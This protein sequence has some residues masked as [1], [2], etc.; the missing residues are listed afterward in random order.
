MNKTTNNIISLI[1]SKNFYEAKRLIHESMNQKLGSLLEEKLIEYA[2]TIYEDAPP[3]PFNSKGVPVEPFKPTPPTKERQEEI[4]KKL[5]D[6]EKENEKKG[7]E[8]DFNVA[9]D[10]AQ[11]A[12][13]Y[14]S[15]AAGTIPVVGQT[16]AISVDTANAALSAARGDY[17]AA[18]LR[19]ASAALNLVPGG[20]L[21]AKALP[22]LASKVGPTVLKTVANVASGVVLNSGAGIA[23]E[24]GKNLLSGNGESSTN[25]RTPSVRANFSST[26]R[27]QQ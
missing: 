6:E 26:S 11:G 7:D 22:K 3:V 5:A 16:V 21:A 10:G 20:S 24:A 8:E 13:D 15:M 9:M 27:P 18:G 4:S 17:E 2:S 12:A 25:S 1:L 14:M 19:A 23:V